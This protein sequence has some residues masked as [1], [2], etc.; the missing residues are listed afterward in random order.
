MNYIDL[1]KEISYALRH[2]PQEYSLNFDE[3]GWVDLGDII[4]ALKKKKKYSNLEV[5]DIEKMI[6]T[7]EKKRH[8]IL[9]GRIRALYGH[10][11]EQ[12]IIKEPVMPPDILFH[13]T[14][15]KFVES[16]LKKGLLAQCRQYVH[17]SEDIET[18]NMAGKRR[19]SNPVIFKVDAKSAYVKGILFYK[20]NEN[21]W[22]SDSIPAIFIKQIN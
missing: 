16:I 7:S 22:L 21:I 3:Q 19:D 5:S 11:V 4:S 10:S 13:G 12:K 2:A 9:D 15:H 8:E 1:S 6:L 14:P 20:G 18:A 17:L